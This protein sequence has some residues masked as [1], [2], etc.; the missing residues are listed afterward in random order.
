M[1]ARTCGLPGC[2]G[3]VREDVCTQCGPR[4]T[5]GWKDNR[6]SRIERGYD[7]AWLELRAAFIEKKT[8]EA[9][10]AGIAPYP[11]CEICE[12]PVDVVR[13]IHVDHIEPFDGVSDP[14]RLDVR[15]LR[16]MHRACHMAHHARKRL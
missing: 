4:K 16:V 10:M 12:K 13:E 11:I 5:H 14:K 15:N 9:A 1:R 8:M 2:L 6:G 7:Q 3:I